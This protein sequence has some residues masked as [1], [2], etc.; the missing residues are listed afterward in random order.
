M[1]MDHMQKVSCILKIL[2]SVSEKRY[3]IIY[4]VL[5]N[6]TQLQRMTETQYKK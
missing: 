2:Y 6:G 1:S 5:Q 3:S 4:T